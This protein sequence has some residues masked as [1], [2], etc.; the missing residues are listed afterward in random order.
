MKRAPVR[1][2]AP[3][4]KLRDVSWNG[5]LAAVLMVLLLSFAKRKSFG[6]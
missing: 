2:T 3:S 6:V 1:D 4:R 5:L